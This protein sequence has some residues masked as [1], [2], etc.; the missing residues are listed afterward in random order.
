M[1]DIFEGVHIIIS[2][3]NYRIITLNEINSRKSLFPYGD[4]EVDN[5]FVKIYMNRLKTFNLK[6][7]ASETECLTHLL[8]LMIGDRVPHGN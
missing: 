1:H 5:S 6:T 8:P 7:S 3:V 4:T 2:L